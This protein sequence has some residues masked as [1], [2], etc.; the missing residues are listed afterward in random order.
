MSRAVDGVL[1]VHL[2]EPG[3]RGGV[4]QHTAA[5]AEALAAA[6]V[7]VTLHTASD[8][9]LDPVGVTL[10]PCVRWY[11]SGP[12]RL[13][14]ARSSAAFLRSTIPHV[15]KQSR[16]A[17]LLHVQGLYRW[18]DVLVR[19]AWT[20]KI[21]LAFSPHN[22]FARDGDARAQARIERMARA[23]GVVFVYSE[24][25][26]ARIRAWDGQ[27]MLVDLLQYVPT[28]DESAVERWR[29]V[30]TESGR[31]RVALLPGQIR[32]DK[33]PVLFVEAVGQVTDLGAAL[34]GDDLGALASAE[35]AAAKLGVP[36]VVR[37]GYLD[38]PEL[39]AAIAAADV[40]V[41]P[42]A[43]ASMSGVLSLARSLGTPTA[44]SPVGGLAAGADI[45]A[46]DTTAK[47]LAT[48]IRKALALPRPDDL[49][50]ARSDR[51]ERSAAE[52]L[53]G[54]DRVLG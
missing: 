30:L 4:Y 37:T 52:H 35:A 31:G 5:L 10:C 29:A 18:N 14:L 9:E 13:R 51:A 25:D 6:G 39:C 50:A 26:L 40:V 15:I 53:E 43:Q 8:R 17:D 42:Y 7:E 27:G 24:P 11:R 38:L 32:P 16:R 3:G 49:A 2:V 1:A 20:E 12:R 41:T 44:A 46:G 19:R 47:A 34:V 28:V 22:T 36:L 33:Q 48:A 45:V 21:P 23:A 54:Y